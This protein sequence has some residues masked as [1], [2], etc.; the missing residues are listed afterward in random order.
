VLNGIPGT[1]EEGA[2]V[3]CVREMQLADARAFLQVH[4]DA[5]RG[6]A[7][8]DYPQAVID[9]WAATFVSDESIERFLSN[10]DEETRL[11][12]EHGNDVVA[13]GA[14]VVAKSE[15]RACYVSPH[16]VRVGVGTVLVT[17]M[18][19]SP[20][21]TASLAFSW[22]RLSPRPRSICHLATSKVSTLFTSGNPA[23]EWLAS[24]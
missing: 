18:R 2:E 12:A 14:L 6:I 11:V 3:I 10:P 13:I 7:V 4:H 16:A 9:D 5:V 23:S 15:L 1:R 19:G 21:L 8:K 17:E 24:K 22:T 20:A